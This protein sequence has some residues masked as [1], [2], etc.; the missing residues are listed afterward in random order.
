MT[1]I[2]LKFFLFK[3]GGTVGRELNEILR[4]LGICTIFEDL[5]EEE[6]RTCNTLLDKKLNIVTEVIEPSPIVNI[7]T[8]LKLLNR[9]KY[10]IQDNTFNLK[11]IAL[12]GT[13]PNGVNCK[14]SINLSSYITLFT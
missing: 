3:T 11:C 12:C 14:L 13:A 4:Y 9:L 6:T 7:A 2:F 1:Q 8:V 5:C 10:M